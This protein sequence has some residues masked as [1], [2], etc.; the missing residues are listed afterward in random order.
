MNI[1]KTIGSIACLFFLFG[2]VYGEDKP[3]GKKALDVKTFIELKMLSDI[4]ISP[5]GEYGAYVVSQ[6][7]I[8]ENLNS[9]NIWLFSVYGGSSK[10]MTQG[11]KS[12][13][14]PRWAYDNRNLGF[15]SN[16]TDSPQI[17][18]MDIKGGEPTQLTDFTAGI[19]D[20]IFSPDRKHILFTSTVYKKCSDDKCVKE[21]DKKT[22][23]SKL[24][25]R[26]I[27]DELYRHWDSWLEEKISHLFMMDIDT[28]DIKVIS[29]DGLSVPPIGLSGNSDFA[30]SPDGKE[31]A[32]TTNT[33]KDLSRSTN[34]DIY[35][36]DIDKG[37]TTKITDNP[38]NDNSPFYSPDGKYVAYLTQLI[39]GFES[40]KIRLAVWDRSSKTSRI[41]TEKLDRWISEYVWGADSQ[42]IYFDS[43]DSGYHEVYSV[44]LIDDIIK[45]MTI[46]T[47]NKNLRVAGN[48]KYLVM[49]RESFQSPPEIFM[50]DLQTGRVAK[51]TSHNDEALR[52]IEMGKWEEFNFKGAGGTNIQGFLVFP[53][54]FDAKK[55]YPW[56][57][58]I[59]GGP[60]GVWDN[61]F[62]P[63]WNSQMFAAPGYV[64]AAINFRG[65]TGY[66]QDFTNQISKDWTGKAYDDIMLGVDYLLL[67]QKFLHNK[68]FCAAGG[69]FGGFMAN[70]L[71]AK[72]DR[73]KCLISH[74]GDSDQISAFGTTEEKWFPEWDIGGNPYEN[75][76]TYKN[77]SPIIYMKNFKTPLLILHGEKDFRV[78][79]EQA[80]EMYT[81]AKYA[82]ID[83][84]MVLFPDEGHWIGK[85]RNAEFWWNTIYDWLAKYLK[86]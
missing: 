11:K 59:H 24:K 62:H 2:T 73:F 58:L 3:Q 22:E 65:S 74:A 21:M 5:N 9:K 50:K 51:L 79:I 27:E 57:L 33:N 85:P 44:S 76:D 18:I 42:N 56:I 14:S 36:F 28:K 16:R 23:E 64:T 77:I 1:R 43:D 47:Y 61:S 67:N 25:V 82:G 39:P 78:P 4:Q 32:Y 13:Y 34:N 29:P 7:N 49:L 80:L 81:A 70:W 55:K 12:N 53:P 17:W 31:I 6:K 15:I 84:K 37:K 26:V 63:R 10:M 71:E 68:N 8:A 83:V 19:D 66:G 35:I 20:F 48:G 30:L 52:N 69:S 75:F 46:K 41:L 54:F 45:K 72:T 60:Q 86:K 38:G 40:D